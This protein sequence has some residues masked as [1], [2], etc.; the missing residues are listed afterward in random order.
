MY[1]TDNIE[2]KA[3]MKSKL[4]KPDSITRHYLQAWFTAPALYYVQ[5]KII[6]ASGGQSGLKTDVGEPNDRWSLPK[7]QAD[8]VEST[9]VPL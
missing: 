6:T 2:N 1:E 9:R 7:P 4:Y 8:N 3:S 5:T